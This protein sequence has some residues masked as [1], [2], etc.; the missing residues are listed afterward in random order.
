MWRLRLCEGGPAARRLLKICGHGSVAASTTGSRAFSGVRSAVCVGFDKPLEIHATA[1]GSTAA[2]GPRQVR[3]R[4][5]AAAINFA[6]I[7]QVQGKYQDKREPPFVAG[8]E[9][10][11]EVIEAGPSS[12]LAVGDR[13]ICFGS[14]GAFSSHMV[15]ADRQCVVIPRGA[16]DKVNLQDAAALLVSYGTAHLALTARGGI[17]AGDVVLVTAAAGGVGLACCELARNMV[18]LRRHYLFFVV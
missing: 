4:I 15:A 11:G 9:C 16:G 10:A 6:D 17:K 12:R 5:A 13:V 8:A 1:D 7:L 14:G 2:L 18:S 3:V